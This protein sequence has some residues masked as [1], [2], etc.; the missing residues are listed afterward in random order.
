[1]ETAMTARS[2]CSRLHA[3]SEYDAL[4]VVD[5][6]AVAVV[7]V[8]VVVVGGGGDGGGGVVVVAA[9]HRYIQLILTNECS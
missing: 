6:D 1:M 8:V 5:D 9:I 2:T 7:V 3:M 4:S